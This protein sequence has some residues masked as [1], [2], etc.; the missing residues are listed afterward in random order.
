MLKSILILVFTVSFIFLL[1]KGFN[2]HNANTEIEQ[3]SYQAWL[4]SLTAYPDDQVL[5][6]QIKE[7]LNDDRTILGNEFVSIVNRLLEENGY[8]K[9][10]NMNNDHSNAKSLLIA[11]IFESE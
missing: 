10:A 5:R 9:G 1:P 2:L 3:Y 8:F 4:D 6:K 11:H 7:S